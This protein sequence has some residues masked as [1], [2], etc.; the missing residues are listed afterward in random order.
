MNAEA[1]NIQDFA[2][3]LP[4]IGEFCVGQ[5]CD[6]RTDA[7][8]V[9]RRQLIAD[10]LAGVARRRNRNHDGWKFL[11]A[12]RQRNDDDGT[13]KLIRLGP[14][15]DDA[16]P[17]FLNFV[18]FGISIGKGDPMNIAPPKNHDLEARESIDGVGVS[19]VGR[20][21]IGREFRVAFD[22]SRGG[23][24]VIFLQIERAQHHPLDH[25]AALP[26]L[27]GGVEAIENVGSNTVYCAL[28][29]GHCREIPYNLRECHTVTVTIR[30]STHSPVED[31][32][33]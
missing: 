25:P 9:H 33:L 31:K 11:G 4:Q 23:R 3:T 13:A 24:D 19:P 16:R 10:R 29:R 22:L 1:L 20:F 5:R 30:L 32:T 17:R 12:M 15:N 8:L 21:A 14:G 7:F 6:S 27:I 26:P 28:G 2:Q 18:T